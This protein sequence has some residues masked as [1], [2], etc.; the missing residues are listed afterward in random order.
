MEKLICWQDIDFGKLFPEHLFEGI[1]FSELAQK[2]RLIFI[3]AS[4]IATTDLNGQTKNA[5]E[6]YV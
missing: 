3:V 6:F 2:S 1:F 4:K 5:S